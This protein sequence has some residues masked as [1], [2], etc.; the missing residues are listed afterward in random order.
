V[1]FSRVGASDSLP[2]YIHL[3]STYVE[4]IVLRFR[5]SFTDESHRPGD[6]ARI[7]E[8]VSSSGPSKKVTKSK[9]TDGAATKT[10]TTEGVIYKVIWQ[11][12]I[13]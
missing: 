7:E 6:L 2:Y 4:V 12:P 8:H 5:E 13:Y 1:Q 10:K 3:S 9:K 11:Y